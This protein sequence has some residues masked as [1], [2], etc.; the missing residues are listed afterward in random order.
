MLMKPSFFMICMAQNQE[1]DDDDLWWWSQVQ[2]LHRL[3]HADHE[4]RGLH[5]HDEGCWC[6]HPPW[7]CWRW[8]PRR[9]RQVPGH[10][11][12]VENQLVKNGCSLVPCHQHQEKDQT[13][14]CEGKRRPCLWR[15]SLWPPLQKLCRTSSKLV[16][17]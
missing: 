4:E 8:C 17:L 5:E 9:F 6:Q 7:C 14:A 2:G 12:R 13:A 1:E 16:D 10:V 11:H 3:R 15:P